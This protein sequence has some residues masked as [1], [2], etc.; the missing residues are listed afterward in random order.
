MG[1]VGIGVFEGGEEDVRDDW[2]GVVRRV[3]W[4]R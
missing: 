1:G 3:E 2:D 4:L